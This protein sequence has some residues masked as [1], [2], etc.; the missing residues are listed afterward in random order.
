MIQENNS[1]YITIN[2]YFF[3]QFSDL[4]KPDSLV[5]VFFINVGVDVPKLEEFRDEF[6][7]KD[8]MTI[9]NYTSSSEI[10]DYCYNNYVDSIG[11]TES[12]GMNLIL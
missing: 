1:Q 5:K 9:T 2:K 4:L 12:E 11:P 10:C 3:L 6:D 7:N 8:R